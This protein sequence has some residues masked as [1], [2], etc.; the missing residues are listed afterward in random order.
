MLDPNS[1]TLMLKNIAYL[2]LVAFVAGAA[3]FH[4]MRANSAPKDHQ[5]RFQL[6]ADCTNYKVGVQEEPNRITTIITCMII[7]EGDAI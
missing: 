2:L 4:I 6:P 7:P 1:N 5:F 3:V